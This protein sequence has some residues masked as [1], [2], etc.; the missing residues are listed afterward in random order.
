MGP[1]PGLASALVG[2][3]TGINLITILGRIQVGAARAPPSGFHEVS[4]QHHPL[5]AAAREA[6]GGAGACPSPV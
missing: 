1:G 3:H 6:A 5:G 4:C 2:T